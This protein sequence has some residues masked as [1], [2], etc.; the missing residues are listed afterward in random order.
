M[1]GAGFSSTATLGCVDFAALN[2]G[3]QPRV[4]VLH[5]FFRSL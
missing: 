1:F 2:K 4:A 3:T 5:D